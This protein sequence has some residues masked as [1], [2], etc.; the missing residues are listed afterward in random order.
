MTFRG[1]REILFWIPILFGIIIPFQF[2]ALPVKKVEPSTGSLSTIGEK[3]GELI[4]VIRLVFGPTNVSQ[5]K[6]V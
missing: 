2:H 5:K 4:I 1:K 6:W 3:K